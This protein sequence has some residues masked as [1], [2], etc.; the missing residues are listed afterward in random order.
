MVTQAS[1]RIIL[2]R[3]PF[4]PHQSSPGCCCQTTA[5]LLRKMGDL[6]GTAR[7]RKEEGITSNKV[8][9]QGGLFAMGK[10]WGEY[11]L[12]CSGRWPLCNLDIK[13]RSHLRGH[14]SR[15][16][17]SPKIMLRCR[18][19]PP[20]NSLRD[21]LPYQVQLTPNSKSSGTDLD[22]ISSESMS[23]FSSNLASLHS[24]TQ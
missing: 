20:S 11:Q 4:D 23:S 21:R 24:R 12:R 5:V 2:A 3:H 8:D 18:I 13:V 22:T 7:A 19:T 10:V 17:G 6:F 14:R 16:R 9:R 15:V 1:N